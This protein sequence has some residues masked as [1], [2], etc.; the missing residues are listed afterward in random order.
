MAEVSDRELAAL[1]A[2]ARFVLNHFATLDSAPMTQ[3]DFYSEINPGIS[4]KGIR[5]AREEA[6]DI[7]SELE[8]LERD[9]NAVGFSE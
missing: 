2:A 4:A 6:L 3:A 1:K 5:E 7:R 8:D 9:L